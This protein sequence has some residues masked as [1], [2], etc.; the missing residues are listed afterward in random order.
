[1]NKTAETDRLPQTEQAVLHMIN[2]QPQSEVFKPLEI[3]ERSGIYRA[4]HRRHREPNEVTVLAG[5]RFPSCRECTFGVSYTLIH[6]AAY[7][8]GNS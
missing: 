7:I 1:M 4:D 5:D 8:H 2:E 3:A 6:P